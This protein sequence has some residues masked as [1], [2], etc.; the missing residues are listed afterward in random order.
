MKMAA[1][2]TG[3]LAVDTNSRVLRGGGVAQWEFRPGTVFCIYI[4]GL[5]IAFVRSE[6]PDTRGQM[7]ARIC[8][9]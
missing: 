9:I 4:G 7:A 6:Y 8:M 2:Q 3:R 1:G 5:G